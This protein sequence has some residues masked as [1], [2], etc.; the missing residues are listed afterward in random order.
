VTKKIPAAQFR[1]FLSSFGKIMKRISTYLLTAT[2]AFGA[3][4]GATLAQ[5]K[6]PT[7]PVR[8]Y[9]PFPAG[10]A[11]DVLLRHLGV[12]L[13]EKW[14]QP[15]V[16][17]NK[18]GGS[19]VIGMSALVNA[20][21]DQ[22][23]FAFAQGS[24]IAIV[25]K[26]IKGVTFDYP[27][28]FAPI[29]LVATSPLVIAVKADAPYKSLNDLVAAG[30]AKA[31]SLELADVGRATVPHLAAE[32][33]GLNSGTKFLHVHFQGGPPAI[34]ATLGGQTQAVFETLGPILALVNGGKLRVL[35]S[36]SDRVEK[37]LEKYPLANASVPNAV[38]Q[39]WFSFLGKKDTS[40]TVVA[41]FNADVNEMLNRA[42]MIA[43]FNEMAAY[44]RPGSP[45]DLD[46][47]IVAE[48]K[49]W[50]VVIDKLGIKPE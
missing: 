28:D 39:G 33:V 48:Q 37:G 10:S 14:G 36:M 7:K 24:A 5:E 47:F 21:Q 12:A 8:V 4:S 26:T 2:I 44:P 11:P 49:S 22:H 25:P 3:L 40:P 6:W 29:A 46:K 15:L 43:K 34:Q 27:K 38:A 17:D 35:A 20:P 13:G 30:K 18:P 9:V 50:A 16:I 41:K 1:H 45:A 32:V 31:E 23:T 19:G 42:D